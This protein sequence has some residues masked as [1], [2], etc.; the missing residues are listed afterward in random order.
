MKNFLF[1]FLCSVLALS[2]IG[3]FI[4]A[5][6]AWLYESEY[7]GFRFF[8]VFMSIFPAIGYSIHEKEQ[9][10]LKNNARSINEL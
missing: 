8:V 1:A 10:E 5:S 6:F 7:F 4:S 9:Q 2:I 3:S